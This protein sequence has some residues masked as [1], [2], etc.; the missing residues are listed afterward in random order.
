[1]GRTGKTRFRF[2][3]QRD[4]NNA[5]RLNS[6]YSDLYACALKKRYE[7]EKGARMA[8]EMNPEKAGGYYYQCQNCGGWHTT[9]QSRAG[10]NH[11][12]G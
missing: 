10:R 4:I 6:Q 11:G 3:A 8:T 5:I 1:V 7:S 12:E 2:T 9:R